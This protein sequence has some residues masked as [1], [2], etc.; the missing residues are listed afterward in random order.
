MKKNLLRKIERFIPPPTEILNQY[1][2]QDV[3]RCTHETHMHFNN[4]VSVYHV[5]KKKKCYPQGCIYFKWKCKKLNKGEPCPRKYKHVG[6]ICTNCRYFYD[7][8]V[9]KRPEVILPQKDFEQFLKDLKVFE[10]WLNENRGRLVE[11]SGVINSIKP[12]YSLRKDTKRNFIHFDGFILNFLE[13]S[14]NLKLFH[15][16]IYVTASSKIQRKFRFAKA[17]SVNFSG[18]FG[19]ENGSIVLQKIRSI[20]VLK[21]GEPCFWTES[22]ARV[23]QRTGSI[24]RHQLDKCYACDKGTLLS[25]KSE[26][27]ALNEESRRKMFCLEGVEEPEW[28]GYSLYKNLE[29]YQ[30]PIG[31]EPFIRDFQKSPQ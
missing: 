3:F 4:T 27:K 28:C 14:I 12:Q 1:K 22:R 9:I 25:I 7:V 26:K 19:V 13:G 10:N 17:D 16:F 23:V 21:R 30:C 18:Y 8:K 2:R 20:E 5:L 11:F 29:L 31:D 6:R 15:D 24:L